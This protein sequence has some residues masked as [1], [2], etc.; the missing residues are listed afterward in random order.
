MSFINPHGRPPVLPW[1]PSDRRL[2]GTL[3]SRLFWSLIP[4]VVA[5]LLASGYLTYRLS[6]AYIH[7]A[8]GRSVRLEAQALAWQV[9]ELLASVRRDLDLIAGHIDDPAKWRPYLASHGRPPSPTYLLLAF[10]PRD[11]RPPVVLVRHAGGIHQVPTAD[12]ARLRPQPA[13][14]LDQLAGSPDGLSL[15]DVLELELPVPA[16]VSPARARKASCLVATLRVDQAAGRP[17]GLLILALDAA[18]LRNRLA[19]ALQQVQSGDARLSADIH[20]AF[21]V[22][23]AGWILFEAGPKSPPESSLATDNARAG[24]T[25]TLGRP[26]LGAAFRPAEDHASFWQMIGAIQSGQSGIQYRTYPATADSAP[27]DLYLAFAPVRLPA[28]PGNNRLA[29]GGVA[30]VQRSLLA[31]AAGFRQVDAMLLITLGAILLIAAILA[32]LAH[33]VT[34]PIARLT[35]A[36]EAVRVPDNLAPIDLPYSGYEITSLQASINALVA[37]VRHQAEAGRVRERD[38]EAAALWE[39]SPVEEEVFGRPQVFEEGDPAGIILGVGPR[40][41]RLHAEMLKAARADVDVLIIGETGTGKQLVAESIHR[42]SAR[43]ARPFVSINC[44]ELDE[45]LLLDT[46]FGHVKGAFTEA[47]G[48]R[49]G[50]FLEAD[51]GIL[52]LDEIQTASTTVQQALLRAIAQRRIKPLGSDKDLKV[53]VRLIAA[54][55]SDLNLLVGQGTFR[56]DLYYRLKVIT[57]H[58][59]ALRDHRASIPILVGHYLR[60]A[61]ILA[62]KERLTLSRGALDK[63]TRYDWPGNVRELMNAITRAVIMSEGTV[64]MAGDLLLEGEKPEAGPRHGT[65]FAKPGAAAPPAEDHRGAPPL[66]PGGPIPPLNRRQAR[67]WRAIVAQGGITRAGYQELVG[68]DLPG[69]TALNDLQDLVAKGLLL[70]VGQGPATRYVP[71]AAPGVRFPGG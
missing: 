46:L 34:R 35:Q 28:G 53:D 65:M 24:Y 40:I 55:N 49:K 14:L 2:P 58:T 8:V 3:R 61:R 13:A 6:A 63:M 47:R 25:G 26:T 66:T 31:E 4:P 7:A 20:F 71:T 30:V 22:D 17:G 38:R 11:E 12:L 39:M 42:H 60:Q 19:G 54:T 23:P 67:V 10:L 62:G 56:Q 50:A 64:I 51:G 29:V 21:V 32:A 16:S 44:G 69:R 1:G 68:G 27:R 18:D 5:I 70:K 15:A 37:A 33:W 57:I 43:A 52:F 41:E 48:D 9:E 36:V 59:P 45:N